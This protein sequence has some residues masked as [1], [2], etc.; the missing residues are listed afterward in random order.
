[1]SRK[2]SISV[3]VVIIASLLV[4]SVAHA[5]SEPPSQGGRRGIGKILSIGE[6]QFTVE[7]RQGAQ[8]SMLVDDKTQYRTSDGQVRS[9]DDLQVAQ[10]VVGIAR[11][12]LHGQMVAHLVIILRDDYDPSQRLG[13]RARGYVT[14]VDL[15][16][17]SFNLL[18]LSGQKLTFRVAEGT[19]YIGSAHNLSDLQVGM[20]SAVGAI[21]QEDGSLMA[22]VVLVRF[23]FQWHVGKIIS[24]DLANDQFNLQTRLGGE[25]SL[26]V[27][28]N[29]SFR[30]DGGAIQSLEDLQPGMTVLAAT[31]EGEGSE[32]VAVLVAAG[33]RPLP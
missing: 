4:G 24:V 6:G 19:I 14:A 17:G 7:T 22:L 30:G 21:K 23:P 33:R 28:E 3:I 32:L 5:Q 2:G 27:D 20:R 1:M 12:D 25:L 10:W 29:T 15:K 9:F 11:Y 13:R 16:G 31:K 18:T 26:K 8:R